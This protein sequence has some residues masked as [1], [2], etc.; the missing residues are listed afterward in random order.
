MIDY[1]V[2]YSTLPKENVSSYGL[3]RTRHNT[4]RLNKSSRLVQSCFLVQMLYK[5]I[6]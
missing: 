5:D 6:Y 4:E 2:G 3:T 1:D